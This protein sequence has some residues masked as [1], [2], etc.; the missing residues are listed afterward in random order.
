MKEAVDCGYWN[1]YR[2]NPLLDKPLTLDS[3]KVRGDLFSYLAK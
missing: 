3:K 1:M 2:F